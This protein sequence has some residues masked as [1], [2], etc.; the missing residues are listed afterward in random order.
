MA[1]AYAV[2]SHL[3]RSPPILHRGATESAKQGAADVNQPAVN[4]V[5]TGEVLSQMAEREGGGFKMSG[6]LWSI[7]RI[8]VAAYVGLCVVM[9]FGQSRYV[10]Y[11]DRLVGLTPAYF[12]FDFETI[13]LTTEDGET[14]AA[15]FIPG[16]LG[17]ANCDTVLFSHGNA[18][19]IG[20]RLDSIRTFNSL[21][22]NVLIYD[23]RGYGESTG[24]PT[25]Q[26]TYL[27]VLAAWDYLVDV[28]GVRPSRVVLFGRSLGGAM[29]IWLAERTQPRA[30]VIESVFTSAPDM[31]ARLFPLLPTRLFC[32][33]RYDSLRA[34]PRVPCPVV[35]LH[36]KSDKTVPYEHG[37]R[38]YE[39]APEPKL[40]IA[41]AGDHNDGGMDASDDA[42]RCLMDFLNE[43]APS[44]RE[45]DQKGVSKEERPSP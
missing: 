32:R 39:A 35:V 26:G 6:L 41:L 31:A 2:H 40:F 22:F 4:E 1:V 3:A 28:R 14:V 27:D 37:Q 33:F 15:W 42:R 23:Y 45:V 5:Q 21:G 12:R 8:G 30:L 43:H 17:E 9:F 11:P 24:K 25:E 38:L 18:G 10:Y 34:I 16:P 19:D 20:D 7:V 44:V 29:A 13:A 36:G